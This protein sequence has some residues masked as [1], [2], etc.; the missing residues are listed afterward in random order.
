M[1]KRKLTKKEIRNVLSFIQPSEHIPSESSIA[2]C[3]NI[4]KQLKTQL[5][6]ITIYPK[7]IPKLKKEIEQQFYATQIQPGECVGIIAAQANGEKQTQANLNSFHK[8]GSSEKQP[9]TSTFSELLNATKKPKIPSC[10][11]HFRHGNKTITQ[12]RETLGSS[13][14]QLTLGRLTKDYEI[15]VDKTPEPWYETYKVFEGNDFE[16]YTDCISFQIDM[17]L[18]YM[19]KLTLKDIA[20]FISQEYSDIYCV[21]SPDCLGRLDVFVDTREIDLPEEQNIYLTTVGAREAYLEDVTCPDLMEMVVC[22]IPGVE[23]MY[24]LRDANDS[25]MVELENIPTAKLPESVARFKKILAHPSVDMTKTVSNN[26]WDI[27]HT[28]GVEAVREY[29]IEK[30][31]QIMDGINACHVMILVDKMTHA[32]SISSIS[33][34]T[35]R[36]DDSGV[37]SKCSFEETL[38]NFLKASVF[39][40][41]EPTQGVSASIIC[42]KK[43]PIGT[44]LC[45]LKMNMTALA[46]NEN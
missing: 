42:G 22:G 13:L 20:D 30:F 25:W 15:Y 32:G 1:S 6:A 37:L 39:G 31:I 12:L 26:I 14:V 4:I 28:L 43:A 3:K 17:E 27:Y 16:D 33:R 7:L 18:L 46:Q 23:N 34:Y 44:G 36:Q 5:K 11:V 29:M 19:Y 24:F 21:Y 8:A 40:Q 9:V 2:M 35:M 45:D 41:D 38:D 10:M